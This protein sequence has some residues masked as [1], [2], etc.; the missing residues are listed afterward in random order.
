V[1]VREEL[2]K[3]VDHIPETDVATVR[4]FLRSL[5]DPVE[6]SLLSAPVDDEP[7]SEAEREAVE[8]ARREPGRGTPHEDVLREFGL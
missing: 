7:E 8:R 2:H 1:T 3:I 4:K 5:V 6:L